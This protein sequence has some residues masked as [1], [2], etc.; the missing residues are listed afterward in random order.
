VRQAVRELA[1]SAYAD[2]ILEAAEAVFVRV[3]YKEAKMADVAAAAGISVGTLYQCFK[4]KEAAFAALVRRRKQELLAALEQVGP[5][6]DPVGR[7]R[8]LIQ[9]V[10]EFIEQRS[11]LFLLLM[12]LGGVTDIGRV[13]CAEA[14]EGCLRAIGLVQRTLEDA[15]QRGD[16]RRDINS[17]VL[18]TSLAG[19]ANG[20]IFSWLRRGRDHSL[21]GQA[22][23]IIN[24]FL[25]G[26]EAQ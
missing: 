13:G 7:L 18:A 25:Q 16:I 14:D 21:F 3:G 5:S 17:W 20:A 23:Q 22:D 24:L 11:T 15:V 12:Q 9:C 19:M 2:A 1:Q 4:N 10:F 26:A 6:D 8:S